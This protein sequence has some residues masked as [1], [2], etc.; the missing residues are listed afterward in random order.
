MATT[1]PIFVHS[2]FRAASTYFFQKFRSQGPAFTCYQEPFNET[3]TAL[4]D[5]VLHDKLLGTQEGS[6]LRHPPLDRPYFYEFWIR[7]EHLAGLY[8]EAFAYDQYFMDERGALP[9]AQRAYLSALMQQAQGRPLLQLCR[10]SGRIA[11]L[12]AEYGGVHV[13]VWREPRNQWWSYR[14]ADYFDRVTQL[15]YRGESVPRVLGTIA[16]MAGIGRGQMRLLSPRE[17]YLL[18]YGLWLDAW[19]R[20]QSRADLT[21]SLD[22]IAI[23]PAENA[24]SS[25]R[26]SE[27]SE[28]AMDLSDVRT[29][30]MVFT[31]EEEGFYSEI[32]RTVS[33]IFVHSDRAMRQGVEAASQAARNARQG[34]E[35]LE[36]DPVVECNLRHA[37]LTM[38]GLLAGREWVGG[39]VASPRFNPRHLRDYW[40][41]FRLVRPRPARESQDCERSPPAV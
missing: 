23:S 34:Y 8:R 36:H 26:L 19:L 9:D 4:N 28:C 13:H 24:E 17:N 27:L 3:L 32:E 29:S 35:R 12:R 2:L 31:A 38:M 5:P 10:S 39:A 33:D 14:V 18:F 1:E 20:L 15:T 22:G 16:S 40:R 30:G 6:V 37:A 11:V 21:I 25:K 41:L 7:R